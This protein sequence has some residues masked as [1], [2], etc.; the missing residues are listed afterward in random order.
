MK[1][2]RVECDPYNSYETEW[3]YTTQASPSNG[4]WP[5]KNSL[6]YK[7]LGPRGPLD[8]MVKPQ[9]VLTNPTGHPLYDL[10]LESTY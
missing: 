6:V 7:Q 8:N 5:M 1:R 9:L 3:S 4:H 2:A 10:N